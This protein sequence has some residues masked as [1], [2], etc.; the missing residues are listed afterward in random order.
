MFQPA[1]PPSP[2]KKR[3][4]W[5]A[6][7]FFPTSW[8]TLKPPWIGFNG[9]QRDSTFSFVGS[10]GSK[11]TWWLQETNNRKNTTKEIQQKSSKIHFNRW[12]NGRKKN[13]SCFV[14]VL[15]KMTTQ[16]A[17][18]VKA[19]PE[20]HHRCNPVA[21]PSGNLWFFASM[22]RCDSCVPQDGGWW[23]YDIWW[24]PLTSWFYSI[25]YEDSKQKKGRLTYSQNHSIFATDLSI[26]GDFMYTLPVYMN[27]W[28][29]YWFPMYETVAHLQRVASVCSKLLRHTGGG[30]LVASH[31]LR[32]PALW[33]PFCFGWLEKGGKTW[34]TIGELE[35][36][37]WIFGANLNLNHL[38]FHTQQ[39]HCTLRVKIPVFCFCFL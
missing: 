29:F 34:L 10:T 15:K 39:L 37:F 13:V 1:P 14:L 17:Q 25:C 11:V 16:N 38:N 3:M 31:E 35:L 30:Q 19:K 9:I 2:P 22:R 28:F 32:V 12:I 8:L 7:H 27:S 18:M 24:L 6:R 20:N 4:T 33:R 36:I 5:K 23:S 26:Y 21:L